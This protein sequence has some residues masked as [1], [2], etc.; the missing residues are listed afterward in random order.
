M[1][2][3]KY[4]SFSFLC[5]LL[6]NASNIGAVRAARNT[7]YTVSMCVQSGTADTGATLQECVH[8][9]WTQTRTLSILTNVLQNFRTRT[10]SHAMSYVQWKIEQKQTRLPR[11]RVLCI[12]WNVS[13]GIHLP[14]FAC[15]IQNV[16]IQTTL[17]PFS[18]R[19]TWLGAEC[20]LTTIQ[21]FG[22]GSCQFIRLV[23]FCL[24]F[25]NDNRNGIGR[26]RSV[27]DMNTNVTYHFPLFVF[28]FY[29]QKI[30]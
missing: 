10:R 23:D 20:S 11:N 8:R 28:F 7:H 2:L 22:N 9:Q 26:I 29:F 18:S 3:I 19:V 15:A 24:H 1:K 21:T 13:N 14:A 17:L 27:F 12:L 25:S 6:E 5:N 30:T 16:S 4:L